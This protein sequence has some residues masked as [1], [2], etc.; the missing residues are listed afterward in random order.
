MCLTPGPFKVRFC[1][2][3][4]KEGLHENKLHI[5]RQI[6]TE[7]KIEK[8]MIREDQK[9]EGTP[10][11]VGWGC[12]AS[13]PKPLR[14]LWQKRLKNHTV[15]G[16]TY[17]YSSYKG[18]PLLPGAKKKKNSPESIFSALDILDVVREL[19]K[20]DQR[21]VENKLNIDCG[22][23]LTGCF[24]SLCVLFHSF[25]TQILRPIKANTRYCQL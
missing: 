24:V 19:Q 4:A 16:R 18:V 11:K 6:K 12:P 10:R 21:C 9:P 5:I 3:N 22:Y 20:I 17:L 15:W 2:R 8:K 1:W 13:F 25:C 7:S 14:Y 23:S